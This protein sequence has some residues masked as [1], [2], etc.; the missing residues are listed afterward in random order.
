MDV[1][2][3]KKTVLDIRPVL[4]ATITLTTAFPMLVKHKAK[5]TKSIVWKHIIICKVPA[6]ARAV[7]ATA[8]KVWRACWSPILSGGVVW[9]GRDGV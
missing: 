9:R 1:R 3:Y 2:I 6:S 4:I 7:V 5:I 8:E